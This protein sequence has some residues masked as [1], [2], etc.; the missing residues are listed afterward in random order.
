MLHM[1]FAHPFE[2]VDLDQFDDPAKTRPHV[3]REG[4]DL[5]PNAGVEQ[6]YGPHHPYIAFCDVNREDRLYFSAALHAQ[7]RA[8]AHQL[9]SDRRMTC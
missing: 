7:R 8:R 3:D 6:F 9:R 5:I 2:T 1:R 4:L